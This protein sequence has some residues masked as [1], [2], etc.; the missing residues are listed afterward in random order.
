M[1]YRTAVLD[2]YTALFSAAFGA[3]AGACGDDQAAPSDTA[4]IE[5]AEILNEVF[6]PDTEVTAQDSSQSDGVVTPGG[7]GAAC[8]QNGDC[9]DGFCVE[10]PEGFICTKGCETECPAAYDCR[11]V[12]SGS[13][14]TVFLCLPR[15]AKV[16]VP[17]KADYQCTGG[18]CLT[19]GGTGECATSCEDDN[20]CPGGYGCTA[21]ASG[22]REGKFCQPRSGSCDCTPDFADAVRT[23]VNENEVGICYG[24]ETCD[25]EAGWQGCTASVATAETCDGRD[26][27]CNALVDDGLENNA[28]CENETPGI[29]VCSGVRVCVGTQ[30]FVCT[31]GVPEVERCDFRDNDCD[32]ETDNVPGRGG[33]CVNTSGAGS[34]PGVNVCQDGALVCLGR[35]PTAERCNYED[36]DCDG[37]TDNGF[38]TLYETCSVSTGVCQRF[39]TVL[40]ADDGASSACNAVA[41]AAGDERCDGLDDDCD[42]A[43]DE[44]FTNLGEVCSTG[45]GVCRG[46]GTRACKADGSGTECSAIAGT[47]STELCDL[48]DNNCDGATDEAFKNGAGKYSTANACGNCFTDCTVIFAKPNASGSCDVAP[49]SPLCKMSCNAGFHDLNGVPDDG[50]E[51]QLE[52]TA[53]YVSESDPAALDD[54]NC[55]SGPTAT[56]GNRKPCRTIAAGLARASNGNKSKVLVAGGAYKENISLKDGVNVFGGYNPINWVRD[57][58]SNMTAIFG[59]QAGGNRKTVTAEAINVNPTTF[60]GF[61]VYGQVANGVGENSYAIWIKNSNGKLRV[62]NNV[63]W[64]GTGGPGRNATRGGNGGNGG[65]GAAGKVV[66]E[67]SL[68]PTAQTFCFKNCA[69]SNTG[70]AGGTNATCATSAGGAGGSGR[71]PDFNE[72]VDFCASSTTGS[73][74]QTNNTGGTVGGGTSG[75]AAGVGGCDQLV[76]TGC[77]CTLPGAVANCP[78][79]QF[80]GAGGIGAKGSA[81]ARGV[82]STDNNGSVVSFEWV[83]ASG[84]TGG[85]GG[86]GAGGGGG[87]AGGGVESYSGCTAGSGGNDFGGSGGGGGAGGCGGSGGLGGTGGGGA[88]GIFYVQDQQFGTNLPVIIDNDIHVGFGGQGGRGGDGGTAGVGGNGGLGGGAAPDG[89]SWCAKPGAQGGNGGDG[90]PGGGG[91]GGAGGAAYGLYAS[92]GSLAAWLAN[93][94]YFVD[95]LGGAGGAGGGTGAG[96]NAG[97]EGPP[98]A[99]AGHNL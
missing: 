81:G 21:D 17:C 18:A 37:Q 99:A 73:A 31:A 49:T 46:F 1:L 69:G 91:A 11:G 27:D 5:D 34:C 83:G 74:V 14:D 76:N 26:N 79:G 32:G 65:D 36:D 63:I 55:G 64:P 82:A 10:G 53:I 8:Q 41:G 58:E 42:G 60:D 97:A 66:R 90:G 20:G 24:V 71:C 48:L 45:V 43:T 51:F 23:C 88:F 19:I 44:G 77:T 85:A 89:T 15:V 16:C 12:Q 93:N 70:G 47:A 28:A 59:A 86:A 95:G 80:G 84:G 7:F 9:L 35:T 78:N 50:C 6:F 2:R 87:G 68:P 13:A 94:A 39:G 61:A 98:G 40:C 56:G 57:P 62:T 52:T 96:G 75:G 92:G 4:P 30:G 67:T 72:T 3:L 54:A 29:G 25:P 22:T 38:G 33:A